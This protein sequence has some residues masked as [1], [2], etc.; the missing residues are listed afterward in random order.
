MRKYIIW[1]DSLI[2]TF[3]IVESGKDISYNYQDKDNANLFDN[4]NQGDLIL[5]Y[6]AEPIEKVSIMF[7]VKDKTSEN[8]LVL[9]KMFETA[10][11]TII[12]DKVLISN[13]EE[14]GIMELS[15]TQYKMFVADMMASI[16][17]ADEVEK[18]NCVLEGGVQISE[19]DFREWL[20]MQIKKNGDG[21]SN[22]YQNAYYYILKSALCLPERNEAES[23]KMAQ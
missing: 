15:D 6:Y 17:G 5:G 3:S 14:K 1:I 4:I 13:L 11:G 20:S 9:S 7:L 19:S 22:E 2:T 8:T 23:V 21:L 12:E 18:M 16:R 10:E